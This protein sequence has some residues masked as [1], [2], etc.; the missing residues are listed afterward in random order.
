MNMAGGILG[1]SPWL[2]SLSRR[3]YVAEKEFFF[4]SSMKEICFKFLE[5]VSFN[6]MCSKETVLEEGEFK[7]ESFMRRKSKLADSRDYLRSVYLNLTYKCALV[8]AKSK[9]KKIKCRFKSNLPNI[10]N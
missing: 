7:F 6:V 5:S 4:A 9:N 2:G 8:I 1:K 3:L 10:P